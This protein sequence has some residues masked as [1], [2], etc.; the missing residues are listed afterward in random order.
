MSTIIII[1]SKKQAVPETP[2]AA[3]K[4]SSETFVFN[5]VPDEVTRV[6]TEGLGSVVDPE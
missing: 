6:I 2:E 4:P 5:D 1:T 3:V